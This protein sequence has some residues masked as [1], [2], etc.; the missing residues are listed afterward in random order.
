[1]G[2]RGVLCSWRAQSFVPSFLGQ[3]K[4][5]NKQRPYEGDAGGKAASSSGFAGIRD[6]DRRTPKNKEA[7]ASSDAGRILARN[8]KLRGFRPR[9]GDGP[10]KPI[11]PYDTE[12]VYE[13]TRRRRTTAEGSGMRGAA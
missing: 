7:D 9:S 11:G 3:G 4:Q 10:L 13:M 6:A 5:V 12:H 1:V 2:A 8:D